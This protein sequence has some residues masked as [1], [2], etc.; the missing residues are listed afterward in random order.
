M[1]SDYPI[2]ISKVIVLQ[3]IRVFTNSDYTIGI[4]KV[5]VL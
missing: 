2:T 5:I 4:S 3:A 1:T